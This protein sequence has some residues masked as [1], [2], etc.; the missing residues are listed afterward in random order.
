LVEGP[1]DEL[2]LQKAY[3]EKYDKL[4][5]ED[6]I[7]VIS[8]KGLSFL[9]FLEIAELL[10]NKVTIVTD[11][12]GDY[13][14]LENKYSKYLNNNFPNIKI[15]YSKNN[16]LETLEPQMYHAQNNIDTLKILFD[17]NNMTD[18]DFE[19]YFTNKNRKTEVAL[20]IFEV[21]KG[22]INFPDYINDAIKQ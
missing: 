22:L 10:N 4:P 11:N 9:R 14:K 12:D 21:E 19:S 16:S 7:D 18:A 6:G 15:C 1:S 13:S 3:L 20:K 2:I 17:K 5:I 8:V